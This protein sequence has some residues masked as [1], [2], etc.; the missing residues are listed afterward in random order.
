MPSKNYLI[1]M[2]RIQVN[3]HV[4]A[5]ITF[6]EILGNVTYVILL[7]LIIGKV[8]LATV[9]HVMT[10]H[11]VVLPYTFLMNTSHNKNRIVEKGWKNVFRNLT[12]RSKNIVGCSDTN[13]KN[14]NSF[15]DKKYMEL[16]EKPGFLNCKKIL[17]EQKENEDN[18]AN[19]NKVF[20]ITT[21]ADIHPN[22]ASDH[23]CTLNTPFYEGPSTSTGLSGH[24]KDNYTSVTLDVNELSKHDEG[25]NMVEKLIFDMIN[26]VEDEEEYIKYFKQLVELEYGSKNEEESVMLK[27]RSL[28]TQPDTSC[29]INFKGKRK[30]SNSIETLSDESP[31]RI[32]AYDDQGLVS[33]DNCRLN[34]KG[35]LRDRVLMRKELLNKFRFCY[36]KDERYY[37]LVEDLVNMEESFVQD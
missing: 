27:N 28:F 14:S 20:T 26:T 3:Y 24:N 32:S 25:Y 29:Q 11:M 8:S 2:K 37:Y 18:Q 21:V 19:E 35:E 4:T 31:H 15:K 23:F 34:L 17:H 36:E 13:S 5:I 10:V 7:G 22:N 1:N 9:I 30:Q 12:G 33:T 6:L 16:I